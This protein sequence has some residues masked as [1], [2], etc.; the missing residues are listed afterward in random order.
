MCR[1]K[2]R[3]WN[4]SITSMRHSRSGRQF[5]IETLQSPACHDRCLMPSDMPVRQFL[6]H[7]IE[8]GTVMVYIEKVS[9]HELPSRKVDIGS[10]DSL[11]STLGMQWSEDADSGITVS[12][13]RPNYNAGSGAPGARARSRLDSCQPSAALPRRIADNAEPECDRL[14]VHLTSGFFVQGKTE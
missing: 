2:S 14:Q 9:G 3:L 6:A 7:M 8:L 13:R 10:S 4:S 12:P 5:P 11:C 1:T